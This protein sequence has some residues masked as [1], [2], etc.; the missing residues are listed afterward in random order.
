LG[1]DLRFVTCL[2]NASV[3][4]LASHRKMIPNTALKFFILVFAVE[5]DD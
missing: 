3:V 1:T 5:V 2:A 4:L